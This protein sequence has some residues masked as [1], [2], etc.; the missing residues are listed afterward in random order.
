[1]A[2]QMYHEFY[3]QLFLAAHDLTTTT[4]SQLKVALMDTNHSA[5]TVDDA[6]WT[7]VSTNELPTAGNYTQPGLNVTKGNMVP[8]DDDSN[9]RAVFDITMDM[10]WSTATFSAYYAVLYNDDHAS[11]GLICSYDF[12]GVKTASGGDFTLQFSSAPAAAFYIA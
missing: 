9:D 6:I 7:D 12:G 1:M 11:D 5:S 3:H 4:G 10:V 8:S 2:D